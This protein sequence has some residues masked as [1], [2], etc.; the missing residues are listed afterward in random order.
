M[1]DLHVDPNATEDSVVQPSGD[2][3]TAVDDQA[4]P[5]TPAEHDDPAEAAGTSADEADDLI[6]EANAPEDQREWAKRTNKVVQKRLREAAEARKEAAKLREQHAEFERQRAGMAAILRSKNPAQMLEM[7]QAEFGTP[8]TEQA[9]GERFAYQPSK[10][11]QMAPEAQTALSEVLNDFAEQMEARWNRRLESQTKPLAEKVGRSE[12]LVRDQEWSQVR[13]KYGTGADAWRK[14]TEDLMGRGM[15][16]DKA[17]MAA[18]DGKAYRLLE[19]R[20]AAADK[21]KGAQTPTLPPRGRQPSGA[22]TALGTGRRRLSD[23]LTSIK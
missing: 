20:R 4:D 11:L 21:Q 10:P 5:S 16:L 18:S 17:I 22:T 1:P 13:A 23:Y 8:A 3:G 19:Q 9:P 12:V 14:D 2:E 7:L 6:D 15:P